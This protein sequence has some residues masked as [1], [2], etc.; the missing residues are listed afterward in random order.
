MRR[1][2][3]GSVPQI[4][5]CATVLIALGGAGAGLA[6]QSERRTPERPATE[7]PIFL[8]CTGDQ[9]SKWN[10]CIT[11]RRAACTLMVGERQRQACVDGIN[12]SCSSALGVQC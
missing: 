7:R 5:L 10:L 3:A 6:V 2:M 1:T 8:A 4:L 11:E 12:S 9:Q